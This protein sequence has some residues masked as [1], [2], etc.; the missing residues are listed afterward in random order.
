MSTLMNYTFQSFNF[1]GKTKVRA[2]YD[3]ISNIAAEEYSHIEAVSAAINV[4]LTGATTRANRNSPSK[5]ANPVVDKAKNLMTSGTTDPAPLE[6]WLATDESRSVGWKGADGKGT[7]ESVGHK[8]GARI[9]ETAHVFGDEALFGWLQA[10]L[11]PS[12][13]PAMLLFDA[14]L[15]CPNL[16]GSRP[17]DRQTHTLF[18]RF[19]AGAHPANAARCG[20]PLRLAEAVVARLG[21]EIGWRAPRRARL[22]VEVFPHPAAVRWLGLE[23]I[24]KYKRGPL[25]ARRAE[26]ARLQGL[27]R[28]FLPRH[29]PELAAS[30]ARTETLAASWTKPHED[31]L[32]AMLCALIGYQHWRDEGRSSEVIG[33]ETAGFI[34][35]PK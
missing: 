30:D 12:P 2:F 27:L 4:L 28:E 25:A 16:T 14:P 9:V 8:E 22:A 5:E 33:D 13:A 29:F 7:G 21:F 18:G 17:V 20:R 32:D 35:L 23:R 26:F 34:L 24:V 31:R 15:L 11:P 19:H 10:R 1:R 3:L 6:K